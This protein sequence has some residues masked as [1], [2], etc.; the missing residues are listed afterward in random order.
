MGTLD[1][2]LEIAPQTTPTEDPELVAYV[3][4]DWAGCRLTRKSTSGR[5]LQLYGCTVQFY[6]RT[7]G[8]IATSA[9]EAELYAI[10]TG[11]A[12]G[13]GIVNF[14][15]ELGMMKQS[16][17]TVFTDSSSAKTIATRLGRSKKTKHIAP[18]Y[19]YVQDLVKEGLVNI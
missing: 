5:A 6:S 15:V 12:E 10:G 18:R 13:L 8:S 1:Y 16:T 4:S 9:G 19:I 7:Q 14:L 17:I 11:V 3:D 2:A